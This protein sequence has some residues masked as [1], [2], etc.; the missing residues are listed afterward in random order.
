VILP[1]KARRRDFFAEDVLWSDPY[2]DLSGDSVE[3]RLSY[4]GRLYASGNSNPRAGH[5]H[6]IRRVFHPQLRNLWRATNNLKSL[7]DPLPEHA[8]TINAGPYENRLQKLPERFRCGEYGLVPLVTEDLALICGLE[9]L[10]LRP[11]PP[12]SLIKSGDI[13]GRLKTLFD[14]LRMPG[15]DTNELGGNRPTEDEIPF[16]CLLQDDRLISQVSVQTDLLLEPVTGGLIDRNDVR[17]IV[18]VRLRPSDTRYGSSG[19]AL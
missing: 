19:F 4:A 10:M 16:Y 11:D 14:A 15:P 8:I 13:D 3:F 17:L 2:M 1:Q 5:K 6:D 7:L 9:I 12:G 18:T